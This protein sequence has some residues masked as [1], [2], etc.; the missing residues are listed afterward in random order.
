MK[1]RKVKVIVYGSLKSGFFNDKLIT[2]N[3]NNKYI[4]A[5]TI[6]GFTLYTNNG[7]Y[8]YAVRDESGKIRG[9]VY[10]LTEQT[11]MQIYYM[12]YGAGYKEITLD[13]DRRMFIYNNIVPNSLLVGEEW[14]LS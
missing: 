1:N 12:E 4:S 3:K 7:A 11:Y 14:K 10:E 6:P 9:E 8:P 2:Y 5:C 13:N